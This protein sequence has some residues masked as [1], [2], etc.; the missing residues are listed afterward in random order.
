MSIC[1]SAFSVILRCSEISSKSAWISSEELTWT[2]LPDPWITVPEPLTIA[3]DPAAAEGIAAAL[4]PLILVV[5]AA[6]SL[7]HFKALVDFE[8]LL[9]KGGAEERKTVF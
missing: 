2:V 4:C 9:A 5:V 7:Y 1:A 3:I 6:I 8:R